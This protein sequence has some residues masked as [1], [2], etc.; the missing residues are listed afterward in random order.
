MIRELLRQKE[1]IL[2][3]KPYIDPRQPNPQPADAERRD[4]DFEREYREAMDR[5]PKEIRRR[6]AA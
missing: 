2:H 5:N 6:H 1:P 4:T 3:L